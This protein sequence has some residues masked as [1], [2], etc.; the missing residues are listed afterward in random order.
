MT[1]TPEIAKPVIVPRGQTVSRTLSIYNGTSSATVTGTYALYDR[2]ETS[3]ATGTVAAGAVSVAVPGSL[4]LG[5]GAY[6]VWS[7]TSPLVVDIRR[8]V[9]VSRSIDSRFSLVSTLQLQALRSWLAIG[10]PAGRSDWEPECEVA[11][12]QVLTRLL[13]GTAM[14]SATALDLWDASPLVTPA[15][16]LATSI[17]CRSAYGMTGAAHFID[18]ATRLEAEYQDWWE[19][20]PLAWGDSTG[21]GPDTLPGP[22]AGVGFPRPS[23]AGGR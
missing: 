17:I 1:Y 12:A 15:I 3:V 13:S 6:E 21:V 7:L 20:A 10:Y 18:E 2:S 11:T 14:S 16:H 5:V 23:P 9:A 19:R 8:P 22:P 4:E